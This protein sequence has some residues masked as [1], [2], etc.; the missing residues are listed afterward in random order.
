[1]VCLSW[2]VWAHSGRGAAPCRRMR[3]A[4]A[5]PHE[6]CQRVGWCVAMRV[7]SACVRVCSCCVPWSARPGSRQPTPTNSPAQRQPRRVSLVGCGQASPRSREERAASEKAPSLAPHPAHSPMHSC[8]TGSPLACMQEIMSL[9][10]QSAGHSTPAPCMPCSA[11]TAPRRASRA[12]KPRGDAASA[13]RGLASPPAA[14]SL[15]CTRWAGGGAGA[16]GG[17]APLPPRAA[18]MPVGGGT[19]CSFPH[20]CC[21]HSYAC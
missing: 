1:M 3:P 13:A 10:E 6:G 14:L 16:A 12:S 15:R 8:S 9:H 7:L 2:R 18:R 19:P 20:P 5:R 21:P 4:R 11:G 17:G